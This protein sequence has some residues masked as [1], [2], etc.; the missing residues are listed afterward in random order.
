MKLGLKKFLKNNIYRQ[1]IQFH[2]QE[3]KEKIIIKVTNAHKGF[4]ME[5]VTFSTA[6]QQMSST[7]RRGIKREQLTKK[8]EQRTTKIITPNPSNSSLNAK[9]LN[10]P[11][12]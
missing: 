7:T 10:S 6:K 8:P 12:K 5:F 2:T 11:I 4:V 9:G 3:Y 1:T